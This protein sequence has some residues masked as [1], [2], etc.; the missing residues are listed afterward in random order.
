MSEEEK[1]E[2]IEEVVT[3]EVPFVEEKTENELIQ[4][5]IAAYNKLCTEHGYRLVTN[6]IFQARD[7]GTYSVVLQ[8]GVSKLPETVK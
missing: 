1:Q 2:V 4:N 8:E 7:D 3:E 5:F 6:P